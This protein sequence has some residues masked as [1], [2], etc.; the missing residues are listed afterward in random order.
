MDIPVDVIDENGE[1]VANGTV[2]ST[3]NGVEYTADVVDGKAT[4]KMWFYLMK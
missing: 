2:K 3:I 4:F 1:S